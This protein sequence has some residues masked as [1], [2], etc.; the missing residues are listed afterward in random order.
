MGDGVNWFSSKAGKAM[1]A[2]AG[3]TIGRLLRPALEAAWESESRN[4][5]RERQR[6]ALAETAQFV[7]AHMALV[8]SF[9]SSAQLLET[10]LKLALPKPGLFCEF[11]VYAGRSLH[12]IARLAPDRPIFGFD[13]FEGLPEDWYDGMPKGSFKVDRLPEVPQNVSLVKGWFSDTLAGFLEKNPGPAAFLHIDCDLYSSTRCI[14]DHFESRI[15]PG[16]V[17]AFDEY[18][19]HLGWKAGEFKAFNE[20]VERAKLRFEYI[21]YSRTGEQVALRIV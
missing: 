19:N 12:A 2:R 18:F 16:T 1:K 3:R 14:F 10:A 4:I 11:G 7:D 20:L 17:I 5:L 9:A 8:P 13:S 6:I 15:G 21:G